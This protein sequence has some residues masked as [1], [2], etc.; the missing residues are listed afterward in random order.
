MQ[1]D[2]LGGS[3]LYTRLTGVLLFLRLMMASLMT[4]LLLLVLSQNETWAAYQCS[5][6]LAPTLAST[7]KL[8]DPLSAEEAQA[9]STNQTSYQVIEAKTQVLISKIK[10]V[11]EQS[12]DTQ[13]D[14]EIADLLIKE[15]EPIIQKNNAL[16]QQNVYL[17][18]ET[19]AEGGSKQLMAKSEKLQSDILKIA[20]LTSQNKT[21]FQ[22]VLDPWSVYSRVRG[23]HLQKSINIGAGYIKHY[24]DNIK[25]QNQK[26]QELYRL[27]RED[28]VRLNE[29][30]EVLK[31]TRLYMQNHIWEQSHGGAPTAEQQSYSD[32]LVMLDKQIQ[33]LGTLLGLTKVFAEKINMVRAQNR[34][35]LM[36]STEV[37]NVQLNQ[38]SAVSQNGIK[39][40]PIP[41]KIKKSAGPAEKLADKLVG[42]IEESSESRSADKTVVDP[43]A[44]STL[45][46]QSD[47]NNEAVAT[48]TSASERE[49]KYLGG[50]IRGYFKR[51]KFPTFENFLKRYSKG[52]SKGQE[53]IPEKAIEAYILIHANRMSINDFFHLTHDLFSHE[54]RDYARKVHM[55]IRLTQLTLEQVL[56]ELHGLSDEYVVQRDSLAELFSLKMSEGEKFDARL[57]EAPFFKSFSRENLDIID[58][59]LIAHKLIYANHFA[60]EVSFS[61]FKNVIDD[62]SSVSSNYYSGLDKDAFIRRYVNIHKKSFGVNEVRYLLSITKGALADYIRMR[63]H[64]IIVKNKKIFNDLDMDDGADTGANADANRD[65]VDKLLDETNN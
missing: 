38:L 52:F 50:G 31:A 47:N 12:Y 63:F 58:M 35:A 37:L 23:Q 16:I 18:S 9:L 6:V 14:I 17:Q 4:S 61:Q 57:I 15:T 13:F 26:W 36:Y 10:S 11:V 42:K 40:N 55:K 64:S 59:Y 19:L 32:S 21:I 20:K 34:D 22:R 49:T 2:A 60:E 1:V 30:L 44:D 7:I 24:Q 41:P 51:K 3:K 25:K 53:I 43:A 45:K 65:E 48:A 28:E 62:S 33:N 56:Q 8:V 39:V 29:S 46:T 27:I 5:Q 54:M